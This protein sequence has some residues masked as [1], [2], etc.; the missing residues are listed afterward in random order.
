MRCHT[1]KAWRPPSSHS[2]SSPHSRSVPPPRWTLSATSSTGTLFSLCA[3]SHALYFSQMW[4][5]LHELCD[6]FH[7]SRA[8]QLFNTLISFSFTIIPSAAQKMEHDH[9]QGWEWRRWEDRRNPP[10]HAQ[11]NLRDICHWLLCQRRW[12][13]SCQDVCHFIRHYFIL[14]IPILSIAL[15]LFLAFTILIFSN[16]KDASFFLY[17]SSLPSS[18]IIYH[19]SFLLFPFFFFSEV[20]DAGKSGSWFEGAPGDSDENF[21]KVFDFA[22]TNLTNS[23]WYAAGKFGKESY[24][25]VEIPHL[26]APV[27]TVKIST[28]GQQKVAFRSPSFAALFFPPIFT[29]FSFLF[30]PHLLSSRT[31]LP[32]NVLLLFFFLSFTSFSYP[33]KLFD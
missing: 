32:M 4:L 30:I 12:F 1:S 19:S 21:K 9:L 8:T 2:R 16:T 29:P 20:D 6:S 33:A 27:M 25:E 18:F 7:D 28:P 11:Q 3:F 15:R 14:L 10:V 17:F 22:L 24:F 26:N 23:I 13:C 31:L 5:Q